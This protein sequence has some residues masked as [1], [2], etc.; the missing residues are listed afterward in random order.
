MI[1]RL[2]DYALLGKSIRIKE[3]KLVLYQQHCDPHIQISPLQSHSDELVRSN[4]VLT[5]HGNVCVVGY[6]LFSSNM[7]TH[8]HFP[9]NV[10]VSFETV[11][12]GV[13]NLFAPS[14]HVNWIITL[15]VEYFFHLRFHIKTNIVVI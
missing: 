4:I 2:L 1:L 12:N 6:R 10:P 13:R 7:S 5:F 11:A 8:N 9:L 3:R 15:T 14:C